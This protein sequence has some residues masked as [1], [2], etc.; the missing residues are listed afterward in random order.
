MT[1]QILL[2]EDETK[3]AELIKKGLV[4]ENYCVESVSRGE[5]A[6]RRLS[7]KNYDLLILDI[8]LPGIDGFEVCRRLRESGKQIPILILTVRDGIQDKVNGLQLGADDYLTK[9]FE[10]D[11]LK[12]RVNALFRRTQKLRPRRRIKTSLWKY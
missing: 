6:L 4:F 10:P 7:K 2:V 3:V 11:E 8:Y 12:A 5:S 9:P 1:A